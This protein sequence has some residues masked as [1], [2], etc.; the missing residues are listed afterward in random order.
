VQEAIAAAVIAYRRL[1]AQGRLHV[2]YPS[3][4]ATNAVRHV[5]NG[6]HVGGHQEAAKDVLSPA[7]QQRHGVHV[8][9]YHV[10]RDG[11]HDG[12]QEVA[13]A[14]RKASVPDLVAFRIDFAEWLHSH[15]SR[16]RQ[17]ILTLASG[18]RTRAVAKRFDISEGRVSQLRRRYE[19]D[20]RAM[21]GDAAT[22]VQ[23][24]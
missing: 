12:W 21:Q 17:I 8:Q 11:D 1:A 6:R 2:A 20:W 24:A 13:I 23:A 14:D 5:R 18:E 9:S 4:I 19:Q 15:T 10:A 7:C 16:D 3:S 22:A